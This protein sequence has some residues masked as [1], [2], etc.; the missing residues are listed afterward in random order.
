MMKARKMLTAALA[1]LLMLAGLGSSGAKAES[2][3]DESQSEQTVILNG[4]LVVPL[5]FPNIFTSYNP[6]YD[7][8]NQVLHYLNILHIKLNGRDLL[9]PVI[10]SEK[11]L[12]SFLTNKIIATVEMDLTNFKLKKHF[13]EED[14]FVHFIHLRGIEQTMSYLNIDIN[15]KRFSQ[16]K[17]YIETQQKM[18]W[19][20]LLVYLK[21]IIPRDMQPIKLE[22]PK[23]NINP[24]IP[25]FTEEFL[26]K[27]CDLENIGCYYVVGKDGIKLFEFCYISDSTVRP[28][29]LS[30]LF[31]NKVMLPSN[32][33]KKRLKELGF[34]NKDYG[35]RMN[36]SEESISEAIGEYS[37]AMTEPL[38]SVKTY[39]DLL[40]VYQMFPLEVQRQYKESD[41][42][43]NPYVDPSWLANR[44]TPP[45]FAEL[46]IGNK[47]QE[48]LAMKQRFLELGY[49]RTTSY[50]DRFTDKTAE[51]VKQFEKNNG[52]PV[53][54]VADAVMLNVLFSD[55]AVGK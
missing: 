33:Q 5:D 37:P 7:D 17:E 28:Y 45:P 54:G 3:A 16:L 34:D 18:K 42:K 32:E 8:L 39:R 25:K 11:D 50:N 2:A 21:M 49:F 48:V 31:T 14:D 40:E 4:E 23:I 43:D 44:P 35:Y 36:S 6:K 53:D 55:K 26:N 41:F 47:G 27:P 13:F 24:T 20:D 22:T 46:T 30:N 52:L 9:L 15:E 1:V 29:E 51:T 12:I 10:R 38:H 19:K